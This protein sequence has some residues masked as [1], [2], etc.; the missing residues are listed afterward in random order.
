MT[1]ILL[2]VLTVVCII[3]MFRF[4]RVKR[5]VFMAIGI[6]SAIAMIYLFVQSDDCTYEK[7]ARQD[8]IVQTRSYEAYSANCV[9]AFGELITIRPLNPIIKMDQNEPL[10]TTLKGTEI[11]YHDS[12]GDAEPNDTVYV[13]RSVKRYPFLT[14][15]D[16][17]TYF[18]ISRHKMEHHE[19][20]LFKKMLSRGTKELE[21]KSDSTMHQ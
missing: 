11:L 5:L 21:Y 14:F 3:F 15:K 17:E 2:A 6:M 8:C 13:Y 7:M 18:C 1:Y 20:E 4:E 16:E 9:M 12:I 10:S 19:Y